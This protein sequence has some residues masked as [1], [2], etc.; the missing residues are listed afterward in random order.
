MLLEVGLLGVQVC[1]ILMAGKFY[2]L[3]FICFNLLY[4]EE[5]E[6]SVMQSNSNQPKDSISPIQDAVLKTDTTPYKTLDKVFPDD[7]LKGIMGGFINNIEDVLL[8][9]DIRN[10]SLDFSNTTLN[11]SQEYIDDNISQ[12]NGD[13]ST[14]VGFNADLALDYNF[15]D[16][17]IS[18]RLLMQYGLVLLRPNNAK[19]TSTET[20]DN[21]LFTTGYTKRTFILK[22]GFVGPFIDGEYQ[23]QFTRN[24]DGTINQAMRY[25]TGIRMLDGKYIDELYLAGVGEIDYS[26]KPYNFKAAIETGIRAK[27]PVTERIGFVYQGFWRQYLGYTQDYSRDLLYSANFNVRLDVGIYRGLALSPYFSASFAKIKGAKRHADNITSGVL[28]L[29]STSIDAISSVK[30]TQDA[31]LKILND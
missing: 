27:T 20:S 13:S 14:I 4:A 29:F 23:G 9:I 26:L 7:Y 25:K 18:N 24:S 16:S 2:L 6:Q 17:R 19:M 15:P 28:L 22:N 12:F 11:V 21:I 31:N 1:F 3:V 10:I 8:K 5:A 30:S